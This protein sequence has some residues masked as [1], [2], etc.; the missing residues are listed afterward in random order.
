MSAECCFTISA[1]CIRACD[2]ISFRFSQRNIQDFNYA[3][4]SFGFGIRY[5]TP[6]GPIRVD[7][8]VSPDSPRFFGFSG[9]RDQLL[10]GTGNAGQPAHQHVPIPLLPGADVL[11]RAHALC[12]AAGGGAFLCAAL[13]LPAPG[14]AAEVLDR[15][16]VT[17]DKQVIAESDVIRYLRVAA[18]LDRKP[19]DLSGSAKRSAAA[20]LV[21]R[22]LIVEEAEDSHFPPLTE[23]D[24]GALLKQVKAQYPGEAAYQ[25]ALKEY[26]IGEQDLLEASA[27]GRASLAVHRSALSRGSP[28]LGSGVERGLR[29]VR[30][31]LARLPFRRSAVAGGQPR[32]FRE[33]AYGSAR[34]G[35]AGSMARNRAAEAARRI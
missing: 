17:V 31:G 8:S 26:R 11:M 30:R 10:A 35:G 19:V 5:R 1:T 29:Q 21:D 34:R 2:D 6:I 27:G 20:A 16:A 9:T 4:N 15:I 13:W 33:A 25:A 7:F 28:N 18:F 3:V 32:R 24:G 12:V 22:Y 14:F 23:E